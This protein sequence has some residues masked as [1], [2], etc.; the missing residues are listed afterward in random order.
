MSSWGENLFQPGLSCVRC[1]GARGTKSKHTPRKKT[2]GN[3]KCALAARGRQP[4]F[5]PRIPRFDQRM[6]NSASENTQE[7]GW[8][9]FPKGYF[10]PSSSHA[11]HSKFFRP[12]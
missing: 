6:L 12:E 1:A 11:S 4:V 8:H 9:F 3:P 2:A 10:S 7:E 5:P